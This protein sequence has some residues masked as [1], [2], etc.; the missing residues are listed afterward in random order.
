MFFNQDPHKSGEIHKTLL[1]ERGDDFPWEFS[2]VGSSD[3]VSS[4]GP[5]LLSM[6]S[7]VFIRAELLGYVLE[8]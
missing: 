7:T 5:G 1:L 6:E 8:D 2:I 4:A 3:N